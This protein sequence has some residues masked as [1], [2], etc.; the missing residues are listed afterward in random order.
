MST[1]KIEW[2]EVC[3]M[4]KTVLGR[5]PFTVYDEPITFVGGTY[6]FFLLVLVGHLLYNSFGLFVLTVHSYPN[7]T[8]TSVS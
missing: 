1:S 6:L 5:C 8:Y 7:I 3:T 4:P 2:G